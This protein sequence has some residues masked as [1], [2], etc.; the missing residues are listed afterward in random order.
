MTPPMWRWPARRASTCARPTCT[1][2]G[3]SSS[4][5]TSVGRPSA[6]P[7]I[8]RCASTCTRTAPTARAGWPT[9]WRPRPIR[10]STP[11]FRAMPASTSAPTAC[12][13]R[14]RWWPTWPCSTAARSRSPCPRT[15]PS[16]GS[17]IS[18]T[19]TTSTPPTASA[20]TATPANAP[21]PNPVN[22]FRVYDLQAGATL[23]VDTGDYP[24]IDSVALSGTVN[25]GL[26]I[27]E[28]FTMTGPTDEGASATLFPIV[29]NERAWALLD[30]SDTDF[31]SISHLRLLDAQRGIQVGGGTESLDLD[32]IVAWGHTQEGIR[33]EMSSQL[34]TWSNLDL[35]NNGVFGSTS[36]AGLYI[37]G[38][39]GGLDTVTSVGNHGHGLYA[40]SGSLGAVTNSS[41]TGNRSGGAFLYYAGA[42]RLQGNQIGRA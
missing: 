14:S 25:R 20:T 10:A 37:S 2:T 11:G 24:M 7:T 26:G 4:P 23:Y 3:R 30:L 42:S 17:T 40:Y 33:A 39:L 31:V 8:R 21:T 36:A 12:V 27:D 41:F 13:C 5:S 15:A 35:R 6:T 38:T 16:S 18:V 9:S 19:T 1:W 29:P 32:H 34:A 22:L 28:G